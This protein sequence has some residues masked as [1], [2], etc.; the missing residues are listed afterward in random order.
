MRPPAHRGLRLRPGGK[1]E[2]RRG[3]T[4]SEMVLLPCI[5]KSLYPVPKILGLSVGTDIASNQLSQPINLINQ[6][7]N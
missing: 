4:E 7:P 1:S 6:F 2:I 5:P 3:N